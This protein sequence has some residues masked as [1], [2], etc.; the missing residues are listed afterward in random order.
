MKTIGIDQFS[1]EQIV[2]NNIKKIYQRAGKCD[3]QQNLKDIL[4]AAMV[5]TPDE[6][7]YDIPNVPVTSTPLKNQ[8]LGNNCVYSPTY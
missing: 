2:L 4:D 5:S 1:F 7:T 6:V 3:D 8:V